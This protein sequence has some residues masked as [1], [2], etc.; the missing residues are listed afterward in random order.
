MSLVS[1]GE[2]VAAV[3]EGAAPVRRTGAAFLA[4]VDPDSGYRWYPE[5]Q[6]EQ[7]RLVASLRQIGIPL[8][9][10]TV[11]LGARPDAAAE[12]ISAYWGGR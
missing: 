7:A 12:H 1:I 10:I 4:C 9:Q 3:A 8:A 2:F 5:V 6:L 11:I